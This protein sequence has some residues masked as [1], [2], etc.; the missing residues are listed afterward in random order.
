MPAGDN[1]NLLQKNFIESL[2][3]NF[4]QGVASDARVDAMSSPSPRLI[5]DSDKVEKTSYKTTSVLKHL[6]HRYNA[7]AS[8]NGKK[9]I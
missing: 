6:L 7:D 9:E 5:V 8:D 2:R 3:N 1:G 4:N